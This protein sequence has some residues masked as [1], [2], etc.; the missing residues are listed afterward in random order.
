[1]IQVLLID[2]TGELVGIRVLGPLRLLVPDEGKFLR[3][4]VVIVLALGHHVLLNSFNLLDVLVDGPQTL[5]LLHLIPL[6]P[7]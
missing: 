3:G 1:M 2:E 6:A 4:V 5:D 7:G